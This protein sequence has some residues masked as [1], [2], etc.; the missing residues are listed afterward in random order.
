EISGRCLGCHQEQSCGLFAKEGHALAG[1]CVDCHMPVQSSNLIVSSLE[2]KQERA[3]IRNHW[4]RVYLDETTRSE[5]TGARGRVS[6]ADRGI[7]RSGQ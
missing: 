1:R 4:I 6:A 2:G 3:Q 7:S 5:K